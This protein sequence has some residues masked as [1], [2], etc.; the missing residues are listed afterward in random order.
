[1]L[2]M[3]QS[4]IFVRK[5]AVSVYL[6]GAAFQVKNA[7][8]TIYAEKC[9]ALRGRPKLQESTERE[10]EETHAEVWQTL[11]LRT[12]NN[13]LTTGSRISLQSYALQ[14]TVILASAANHHQQ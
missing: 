1:M 6:Q 14:Q 5:Q 13:T 9:K 3:G 10:R 2:R 4:I 7:Q 8:L 12:C 11:Q